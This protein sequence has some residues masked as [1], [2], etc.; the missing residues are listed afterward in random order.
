M[1]SLAANLF[2]C[3]D[4]AWASVAYLSSRKYVPPPDRKKRRNRKIE[5]KTYPVTFMIIAY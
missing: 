5:N 2:Y 1:C 4:N 3:F